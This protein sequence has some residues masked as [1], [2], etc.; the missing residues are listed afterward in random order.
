MAG[1]TPNTK[2]ESGNITKCLIHS[3]KSGTADISAGIVDFSYFESIL[4]ASVR[5]TLMIIDTG[6]S[7]G[8]AESLA[9]LYKLKLTGFEKVEL[10]FNDNNGNKLTFSGNNALYIDKIRNVISSSETTFYVLDLVSKELLANDF[11]KTE[12]YQRYDGE[13]SASVGIILKEVLKS[14]KRYLSDQSENKVNFFGSGKKPFQV[15]P[16]VAKLGIPS[17]SKNS[18]GYLIFETYDGYNFKGIDKLF[19]GSPRK[20][21]IY[22]S[23]TLLPQGYDAKIIQYTSKKTVDTQ[24]NLVTGAFG[25]RLETRNPEKQI[26][27]PK[28]KEVKNKDQKPRGGTE[29]SEIPE[30]FVRDYGETSKRISHAMDVGASPSG[31]KGRQ[32]EKRKEENVESAKILAQ[33][34]MT[35]NKLFTLST[36]ITIAGDFSLRA[37][38]M[39]HCDFPEQSSKKETQTNK[40]LSGIYIISDICHYLTPKQCL[41]IMTLVRD[42]YGRKPR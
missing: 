30:E 9:I 32:L 41:T 13:L 16:E 39:I 6:N 34:A 19:D 10:S 40:E 33:S 37:G 15:I 7:Q 22:N 11:L 17:G 38:Q 25:A 31:N 4:D 2:A 27:N 23:S 42:S 28:A 20:K 14:K 1:N 26:F 21:L 5:V 18:A 3:K 29:L 8:G 24:K 12:V 36:D 35:Y